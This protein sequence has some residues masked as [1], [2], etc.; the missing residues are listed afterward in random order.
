MTREGVQFGPVSIDDLNFE[1]ERGGL[2]PE[3]V[4]AWKE[5]MDKW[6]P[7]GQIGG[8]FKNNT[9]SEEEYSKG[10]SRGGYIF[11]CYFLPVIVGVGVIFGAEFVKANLDEKV[12]P[13]AML[14]LMT[15]VIF[16]MISATLNRFINLG[17]SRRWFFGL[18]V[19]F[20]NNWLGYR[21]FACPAGYA[22][23]KKLGGAG[24]F[25]AV[26]YWLPLLVAVGFGVFAS[27][28]SPESMRNMM[29]DG[30]KKMGVDIENFQKK[31]GEQSPQEPAPSPN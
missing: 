11:I 20:L 5:G 16:L 4:T 22:E 24:W 21:L 6:I 13:I 8:F 10:T 29:E 28:Q 14:A 17:M 3:L 12:M 23:H 25:L 30:F 9:E 26:I 19:P 31:G 15:V 18:L 1:A 2:D 7:V 27:L